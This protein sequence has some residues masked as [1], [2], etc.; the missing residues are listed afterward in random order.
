LLHAT[1]QI[2]SLENAGLRVGLAQQGPFV[3]QNEGPL[4]GKVNRGVPHSRFWAGVR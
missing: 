1:P 3:S 2:G 4:L